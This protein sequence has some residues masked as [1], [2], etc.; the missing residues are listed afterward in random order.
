MG[1]SS[2]E[3]KL[4][5]SPAEF[6]RPCTSAHTEKSTVEAVSILARICTDDVIA[7]ALNRNGLL[8]GK[9]NRWTRERVT[10]LRSWNKIPPAEKRNRDGWLNLTQA[11]QLLGV[12]ARTLRIAAQRNEIAAEHPFP[13]GPWAFARGELESQRAKTLI[14]R[15]RGRNG[16]P[17]VPTEG[18]PIL[19]FSST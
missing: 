9:G 13:D 11:S 7:G 12:S 1:S 4:P 5:K 17:A 19:D 3:L 15:V 2:S 6:L 14:N 16:T 8:T 10:S 18:Q